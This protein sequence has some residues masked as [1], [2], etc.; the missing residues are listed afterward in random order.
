V[1][2][3]AVAGAIVVLLIGLASRRRP[4]RRVR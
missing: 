3:I 1:V 4:P 2:A